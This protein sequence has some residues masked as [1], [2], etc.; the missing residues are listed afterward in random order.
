MDLFCWTGAGKCYSRLKAITASAKPTRAEEKSTH[1][2]LAVLAVFDSQQKFC[3]SP[4]I[5]AISCVYMWWL[6]KIPSCWKAILS[7][8]INIRESFGEL[9]V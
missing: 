1:N 7:A 9:H 6:I 3:A 5:C 4:S 8:Q 2:I